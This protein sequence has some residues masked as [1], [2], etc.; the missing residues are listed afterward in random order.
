MEKA[1][2]VY[3]FNNLN[4]VSFNYD[5]IYF[6]GEFCQLR[7]PTDC[8]I[9]KIIEFAGKRQKKLTMMTPVCN[10]AVLDKI[11][12]IIAK[13]EK[14][15]LGFGFEVVINDWGV[16]DLLENYPQIIKVAGRSLLNYKKDPRINRLPV[17]PDELKYNESQ[18]KY[19]QDFLWRN[20]CTRVEIDNIE[21]LLDEI[22]LTSKLNCSVYVPFV[23]VTTSRIC[24]MQNENIYNV[25]NELM[26]HLACDRKCEK[27]IM[28]LINQEIG[29]DIYVRGNT[30][31]YFTKE[32]AKDWY[33]AR[34]VSRLVYDNI[35]N[36][37]VDIQCDITNDKL[38]K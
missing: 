30:Q 18:S 16:F 4:N 35:L 2:V 25:T 33:E 9:E 27:Y 32:Y 6:G 1:I 7:I 23:C 21:Y 20:G 36:E 28:K 15:L 10:N 14:E 11:D 31:Y 26:P 38:Q 17:V 19:M 34:G 8:E 3:D 29:Q 5:R 37:K 24:R 13:Y 22:D 12:S